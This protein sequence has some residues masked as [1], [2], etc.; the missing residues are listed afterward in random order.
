MAPTTRRGPNTL[1]NN[2]NPNNMTPESIQAMIDQSL[3]R[4]STNGDGSHNSHED[5]RRNVQTARPCFYADLMKCQ[6]LN[7]KG[8]EGVNGHIRTL[9]PKAYAMTWEVLK[10]KMTDKYC[11]QGEIK[12]LEIELWNLK[13]KGNDIPAYTERFQE[14]TLICTKFVANET[15]KV[16]KYLSGLPDNIYG[17]VKA[18]KPKT[19]DETIELANDLMDRKLLTY[20][21]RQSDNK[22]KADDSSRNN[23]GHQQQPFKRQNVAR[24]C[25]QGPIN[26]GAAKREPMGILAQGRLA[27]N[28]CFECGAPGHFKRDCPKLKNKDGGNG[29]AQGWVYAVGNAEKRGNA[30]GNPD[31]NVVTAQEYM[32]KGCQEGLFA[33][34]SAKKRERQDRKVK[35][36]KRTYQSVRDFSCSIPE[37]LTGFNLRSTSGIPNRLNSRLTIPQ[38]TIPCLTLNIFDDEELEHE[39]VFSTCCFDHIE[40]QVILR[41]AVLD[42]LTLEDFQSL[43]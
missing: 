7:F 34:I 20:A 21:E 2:T 9:G 17:N 16:D 11:P 30:S 35:T 14:L 4:N 26:M 31:A 8:T 25:R 5:N 40:S 42:D 10:R 33:R 23:H 27:G 19:L 43:L 3:L 29:N 18:A 41:S 36:N 32:A 24:E 12:K 38:R 13:V 1:V 37:D 28:G 6:P 22:R 15:E 39:H